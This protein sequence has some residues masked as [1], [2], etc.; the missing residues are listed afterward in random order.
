MKHEEGRRADKGNVWS[1]ERPILMWFYVFHGPSESKPSFCMKCCFCF[2]LHIN[3]FLYTE[4]LWLRVHARVF[5]CPLCVCVEG[6]RYFWLICV[7]C[8]KVVHRKAPQSLLGA[9]CALCITPQAFCFNFSILPCTSSAFFI[10][11][12][13]ALP[14]FYLCLSLSFFLSL[15]LSLSTQRK[16]L[17]SI[18]EREW[19]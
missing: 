2:F 3:T 18:Y 17:H 12:S 5:L 9:Q 1:L 11:F 4:C 16:E 8:E 13:L 10:S 14:C 7:S 15:S 19:V 6:E